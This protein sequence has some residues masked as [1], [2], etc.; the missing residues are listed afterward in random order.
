MES[1]ILFLKVENGRNYKKKKRKKKLSSF[2]FFLSFFFLFFFNS[3][4]PCA[5]FFWMF[6]PSFENASPCKKNNSLFLFSLGFYKG[7]VECW[8]WW[9]LMGMGCE[10][11]L[12]QE[13]EWATGKWE[14]RWAS[15][16]M[17][18]GEEKWASGE[19]S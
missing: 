14:M 1:Y 17:E 2:F 10:H 13:V 12:L 8:G 4:L 15:E 5:F 3:L 7:K 16:V 11:G 6:L 19:N 18:K 9:V